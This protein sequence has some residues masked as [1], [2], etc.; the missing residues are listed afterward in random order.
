MTYSKFVGRNYERSLIKSYLDSP[1][2]E[3]VAVYGR[4]RVGKTFLVNNCIEGMCDFHFTG[5][6]DETLKTQLLFFSIELSKRMKTNIKPFKS[7]VD[8]FSALRDYLES[9][10]KDK[11]VVFFD[12]LPWMDAPKSK[13]LTSLSY[14][15]NMWDGVNKKLKLIVCGSST[16]WMVNKLIGDKGGLYGRVGRSIYLAPFS[17][18]ECKEFLNEIKGGSYTNKQVLDTYMIMGGIPYYLDMIDTNIPLSKNVDILF[19]KEGAP[20]RQEFQFLFRSL[21]KESKGYSRVIEALSSKLYGMNRDEISKTAGVEGGVLTEI[22][23]NL[24]SCDFIKCYFQINKE[25]KER[26]Y[27]LTDMFSLFYLRFLD[28]VESIDE[29]YWVVNMNSP[30]VN[31]WKGYAF[32]MTC[33]N[34]VNEIKNALGISGI[35]SSVYTWRQKAKDGIKGNQ[36]DLLID[37]SDDVINVIEAKYSVGEYSIDKKYYNDLNER[38]VNFKDSTKTR[39]SLIQ[40]FITVNGIKKNSYYDIVQREILFEDLFEKRRY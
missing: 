27:Q 34:H 15:W 4:R 38:L 8:A 39:K 26:I 33:L 9:L 1:K 22:L 6:C 11:V 36:I 18:S 2:S 14:F 31:A 23:E 19:F 20:L 16:T 37:R 28:N 12:E 40:T 35:S 21:F 10:N 7:W 5:M 29:N 13:F 32:E 30:K 25:K 3:F 24:H 17:L